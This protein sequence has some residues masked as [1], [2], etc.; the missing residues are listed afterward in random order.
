M[1]MVILQSLWN[2]EDRL[3]EVM[4]LVNTTVVVLCQV[5]E[6]EHLNL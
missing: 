4:V 1:F 2:K 5:G 3:R 6:V